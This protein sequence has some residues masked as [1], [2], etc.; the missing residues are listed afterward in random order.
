MTQIA[1]QYAA[2]LYSLAAEEGLTDRIMQELRLLDESFSETPDYPRLLSA[3]NIPKE[4]RCRI[5]DAGFRGR[6]HPYL[7]N[8]LKILTEKGYARHFGDCRK[9]YEKQY[10]A[11]NGILP[12]QAVTAVPLS[13]EQ[14]TKL[15]QKLESMTGKTIALSNRIDPACL[16][17]VQLHY[18]GK[19]VDGTVKNRLDTVGNLLKE[20]VL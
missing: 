1:V 5:L 9:A 4:E 2:A 11:E 16:G 6:V 15:I 20:T 3:P 14:Q 10:N 12:V 19:Q 13:A 18:D 8:F 7:L 17:G